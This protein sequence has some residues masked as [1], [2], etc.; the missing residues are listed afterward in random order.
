[1]RVAIY[2][3][4]ARTCGVTAYSH[5]V[6]DGFRMLGIHADVVSFTKSGRERRPDST[7]NARLHTWGW[8][9]RACDVYGR[10]DQAHEILDTYD[11]VY[12][13]EPKH[14]S[15]DREAKRQ[16]GLPTYIEVLQKTKTP[17][18]SALHAPL[19]Q[20]GKAPYLAEAFAAGN[21]LGKL[22]VHQQG[23]TEGM[24]AGLMDGIE[25]LEYPWVP[26]VAQHPIDHPL[27]PLGK[28]ITHGRFTEN[29]GGP[30]VAAVADVALPEGW[31]LE[32]NGAVSGGNGPSSSY[33][34]YEAMYN[35]GWRGQREGQYDTHMFEKDATINNFGDIISGWPWR[36]EKDG[37][38][39]SYKGGYTSGIEVAARGAV[40]C[41][42]T[43]A[44]FARGFE[45]TAL[46][47]IDA[48]CV[49]VMPQYA[50]WADDNH[51]VCA[52][53]DFERTLT[54]GSPKLENQQL[55]GST[56][57]WDR[58]SVAAR[59]ELTGKLMA[60]C[61]ATI[62]NPTWRQEVVHHNREILRQYHNPAAFAQYILDV[63]K[64]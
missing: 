46:E 21:F 31:E 32:M 23:T 35:N 16:G 4:R 58:F 28:V 39:V 33:I 6:A 34:V 3:P 45:L 44:K 14:G 63:A 43:S 54:M 59:A 13:N 15:V 48:G 53:K 56:W 19:Y 2:E 27:P 42:L 1:M 38:A 7:P 62:D 26:Y 20:P 17:W 29:K 55:R 47:A 30:T 61:Q 18:L 10:L 64:A 36:V 41:A 8:F 37:R 12:L 25:L 24:A 22:I 51:R 49:L 52:L 5:H 11:L 40:A 57:R 50:L 9:T 60:T